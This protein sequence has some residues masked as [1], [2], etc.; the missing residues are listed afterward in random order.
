[1][2]ICPI[3]FSK[4]PL[5]DEWVASPEDQIVS[6]VRYAII[7]PIS[8]I[9]GAT[10]PEGQNN[11][12]VFILRPKKCYN[13]E[14]MRDHICRAINYFEKYFD[15]DKELL[16][17]IAKIKYL[18][19]YYPTYSK[20]AFLSDLKRFI[21]SPSMQQKLKHLV[22][23]N[24]QI[25]LEYKSISP[26]LQY[27]DEHVKCLLTCMMYCNFEIPL[28]THFIQTNRISGVD[29]FILDAYD[30]F[31]SMF[32][33]DIFSKLCE[34]S[35]TNVQKTEYKNAP[36]WNK[37]DIRGKD[38]VS[39]SR[40]N[41]DNIILNIMPKYAFNK[42]IVALNY[43]SITKN[44]SCQVLDISYEY[45]FVSLSSSK[46]DADSEGTSSECDKH[47]AILLK[48]DEGLAI[49][50]DINSEETMKIIDAQFGPFDP[51]EIEFHRNALKN[52]SGNFINGFQKQLIYHIFYK[53]FNDPESIKSINPATDYIKLML[54]AR[55]ILI[56]NNCVLMPYIISGKVEKLVP[57]K[58]INK[59]EEKDLISSPYYPHL[60]E[61]YR[62]PKVINEILSD[63]ATVISSTFRI[64]DYRNPQIHGNKIEAVPS[65]IMEELLQMT[66]LY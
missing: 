30:E 13:S 12:D 65:I 37:Q 40:D 28:I 58:S 36:L 41:V 24:Y 61:K 25:E 39:Q 17:C 59:K 11:L 48:Q 3:K 32:D 26:S 20:E 55:K 45:T 60:V 54:A 49:Q 9:L 8:K 16:M 23:Y 10:L 44:V 29:D 38:V 51:A 63:F 50:N 33:T 56:N 19:D 64:I 22:D 46:R 18:I 14:I 21:L 2:V 5:L 1:M 34:T 15:P 47:Q 6:N 27:T 53:Y 66:L 35:Y 4:L 62:N 7:M 43:T 31:L 42:N 52:S 57:R